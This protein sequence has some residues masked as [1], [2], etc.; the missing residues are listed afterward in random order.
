M[1]EAMEAVKPEDPIVS[2]VF[3]PSVSE[4]EEEEEY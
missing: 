3:T 2:R 4:A 1:R